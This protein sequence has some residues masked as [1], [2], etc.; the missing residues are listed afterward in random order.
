MKLSAS[1]AASSGEDGVAVESAS[2][3]EDAVAAELT[4]SRLNLQKSALSRSDLMK[5]AWIAEL[6]V[7][8]DLALSSSVRAPVADGGSFVA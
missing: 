3:S 1:L 8:N 7:A 5:K 2:S 4:S 6:M